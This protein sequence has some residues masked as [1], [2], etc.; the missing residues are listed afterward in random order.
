MQQF[1]LL[2]MLLVLLRLAVSRSSSPDRS[3]D[4]QKKVKL[5]ALLSSLELPV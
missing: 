1:T 2:C 3:V 5:Q 4:A